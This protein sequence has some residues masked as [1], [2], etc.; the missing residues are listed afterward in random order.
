VN[1]EA[2]RDQLDR[3]Q[4]LAALRSFRRGDFTVRLPED[5]PGYDSEIARLFNEIVGLNEG[6]A[7]E[8]GRWSARKA[9]SASVA[10]SRTLREAGNR[11]SARST[12]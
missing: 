2:P 6:M 5:L 3:R 10:A 7:D 4:L 11:R 12:T 1:I 8:L 9:R